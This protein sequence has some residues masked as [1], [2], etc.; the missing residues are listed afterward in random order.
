[1]GLSASKDLRM[2]YLDQARAGDWRHEWDRLVV[3]SQTDPPTVSNLRYCACGL[4]EESNN[5]APCP[6]RI[7]R[8]ADIKAHEKAIADIE[9]LAKE[10]CRYCNEGYPV[11]RGAKRFLHDVP[12]SW[13][14]CLAQPERLRLDE[15]EKE[16]GTLTATEGK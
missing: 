13:E 6:V 2:T 3:N 4:S 16:L 7:A 5:P 1:M 8:F 15:L 12:L 10:R 14:V 11:V 9:R